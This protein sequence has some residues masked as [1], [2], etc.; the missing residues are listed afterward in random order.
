V[1]RKIDMTF[2]GASKIWIE[3][4]SSKVTVHKLFLSFQCFR[5]VLVDGCGPNGRLGQNVQISKN[6]AARI[7]SFLDTDRVTI[8]LAAST[9][10]IVVETQSKTNH[11]HSFLVGRKV[12]LLRFLSVPLLL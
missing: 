3:W 2:D 9:E 10:S 8:P 11:V 12:I 7:Y 6:F 5:H 1:E 4:F